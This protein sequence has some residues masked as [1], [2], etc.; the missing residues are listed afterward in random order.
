[1][2]ISKMELAIHDESGAL[3]ATWP[4]ADVRLISPPGAERCLLGLGRSGEARL[5][6]A[7]KNL[8]HFL[9]HLRN[10][11]KS[12][13]SA[14]EMLV[15]VLKYGILAGLSLWLLF[16]V[17]I[18]QSAVLIAENLPQEYE[19]KLGAAA[20]DQVITL[21]SLMDG[22][23]KGNRKPKKMVCLG[24]GSLELGLFGHLLKTSAGRPAGVLRITVVN[25]GLVNAFALP[26]NQ[27]I[28]TR[29]LID[30]AT[31]GNEVAAVIAHEVGHLAHKHPT[32]VALQQA[33]TAAIVGLMVG[34]VFGGGAIAALGNA[35]LSSAYSREAEAEADDFAIKEMN[36]A[37]WDARPIA[38]FFHRLTKKYGDMEKRFSLLASHPL[39]EE[40]ARTY[41]EQSKGTGLAFSADQWRNIKALCR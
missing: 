16:A 22:R 4:C 31:N 30:Q 11:K 41:L 34:D 35:M 38:D 33:G 8:D 32:K 39:S 2:S 5:S 13:K 21:L 12:E 25:V 29:G 3:L 23:K 26:G 40:R 1:M 9:P 27:I 18:P 17:I 37:N 36:N 15:P 20:R 10:L 19:N 7:A 24:N 14:R 6:I 28:V